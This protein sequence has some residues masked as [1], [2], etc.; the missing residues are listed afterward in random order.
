MNTLQTTLDLV[1]TETAPEPARAAGADQAATIGSCAGGAPVKLPAW[2]AVG[3]AAR[4]AQLKGVGY[5]LVLDRG[6]VVGTIGRAALAAA[7]ATDLLAR[8]MTPVAVSVTPETT[9]EEAWRLMALQGLDCLPVVS[10]PLLMGLV[11]REEL[12]A[13]LDG[14]RVAG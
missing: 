7:P 11:T 8:W 4:V 1:P 12:G 3:A 10:G 13:A 2:F 6:A 9:R 5:L 14:E